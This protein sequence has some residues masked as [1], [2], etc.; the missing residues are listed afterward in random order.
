[1]AMALAEL[2]SQRKTTVSRK[3][4][5]RIADSYPAKTAAIFKRERDPFANPVGQTILTATE[6]IVD[7]LIARAS[8]AEL[9]SPLEKLV[10]IRSI[11][12]FSPSQAVSFVFELRDVVRKELAEALDEEPVRSEFEQF[13]EQIEKLALLAFD[14]YVACREQYF[15]V[16]IS[17]LKRSIASVM[18]RVADPEIANMSK[19][20]DAGD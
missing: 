14:I 12:D 2:L 10:R 18:K 8:F 9:S 20:R 13:E 7:V 3:W 15:E 11:Q 5:D 19:T 6:E 16:R 1:M 4:R 17:E